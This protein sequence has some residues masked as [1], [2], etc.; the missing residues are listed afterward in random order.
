[1]RTTVDVTAA[2]ADAERVAAAVGRCRTVARLSGGRFGE[3]ATYLPGRRVTGV[4]IRDNA[5]RPEVAVHVVGRYG[6]TMEEISREV[7]AAVR[8]VLPGYRVLV[9]IDDLDI[10][11]GEPTARA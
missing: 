6:P 2:G 5:P 4:A 8:S 1:V 7:V 3:V 9:G 11:D 10:G